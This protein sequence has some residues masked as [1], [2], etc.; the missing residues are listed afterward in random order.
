[1]SAYIT[2]GLFQFNPSGI[3]LFMK[4]ESLEA[5]KNASSNSLDETKYSYL[6]WEKSC[7]LN[8]QII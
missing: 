8:G 6:S 4:I 5:L 7:P 1:M 2:V 3:G